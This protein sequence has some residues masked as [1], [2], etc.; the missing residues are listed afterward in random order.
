MAAQGYQ[1]SHWN[2]L[3]KSPTGVRGI[4]MLTLVTAREMGVSN[5]LDPKQSIF[6]GAKYLARLRK[7]F[8]DPESAAD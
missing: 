1:E 4:M 7:S 6:E 2:A 5:R 3:A 8:S